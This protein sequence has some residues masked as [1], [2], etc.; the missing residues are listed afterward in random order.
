MRYGPM[1]PTFL[2]TFFVGLFFCQSPHTQSDCLAQEA[3]APTKTPSITATGQLERDGDSAY[4]AK[5]DLGKVP[6]GSNATVDL[7]I[8]N[9]FDH[10][11]KF[12]GASKACK[13]SNFQPEHTYFGA[14]EE[15][16][17]R[18]RLKLPARRNSRKSQTSMVIVNN[19][20][21]I[22]E[23][24]FD[25][26]LEGLLAFTELLGIV[27]FDSDNQTKV[28]EVPFLATAPVDMTKLEIKST[29]NLNSCKFEI[30]KQDERGVMQITIAD[31]ILTKSKIR[32]EVT[33]QEQGTKRLDTFF[34]TIKND[35]L[36]EISPDVMT[37]K[38]VD[39]NLVATATLKMSKS[40]V[41]D[42]ALKK[43]QMHCHFGD[44]KIETQLKRISDKL[45]SVVLNAGV[46]LG[47][48][49]AAKNT[50][51]Q[52]KVVQD[53]ATTSLETPFVVSE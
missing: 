7:K 49:G 25:Y 16:S 39:G 47:S 1:K 17:A 4:F 3:R 46:E 31:S 48:K 53:D 44:T 18:V 10:Q 6:A 43:I 9:P 32:G 11:I 21:P 15:L 14:N 23:L 28:Y 13:C 22:V 36:A 51:L 37:F 20:A 2:L 24:F 26:E 27:G 41:D 38:K 50:S 29:E 52:W 19:D 5:I 42:E 45:I 35:K 8:K 34:L 30:L 12:T 33:I 40:I